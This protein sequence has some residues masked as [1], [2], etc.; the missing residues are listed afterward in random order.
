VRKKICITTG[1]R[2]DFGLFRPLLIKIRSAQDF[3][4]QLLV[5]GAHLSKKFGSTYKEIEREGHE[6]TK[7]VDIQITSDT[8]KGI[9]RSIGL[10]IIGFAKAL[11]ELKPDV[12]VL[13]GDRFE[14]LACAIAAHVL[15][16]PI[17]HIHGG[18]RTEG[19]IDDAFRHAITKMSFLHFTSAEEYRQRV[20]Q[21]GESP[22]RVFNVGALGVDNIK[23]YKLLNKDVLGKKIGF[24]FAKRNILVTFHPVTLER[25]SAK[26]QFKELL[27]AID[28]FRDIGVIFTKPNVDTDNSVIRDLIDVYVKKNSPRAVCFENMG[29]L[30]YLSALQAV[31]AVVGNSSSG[32]IEAP[33]FGIPT[34][35]IGDRQQ[36]RLM[37]KS[38]INCEPQTKQIRNA[39]KKAFSPRFA[40]FCK[41]VSNPYGAGK[42]AEKIYRVVRGTINNLSNLKKT[43]YTIGER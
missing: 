34:I 13:L 38:V 26:S 27:G 21:L 1:S 30:K 42:A 25:H 31:A 11:D 35:N 33:S 37:A 19:V 9:C 7:K 8:E 16:I 29:T 28:G 43:F 15:K 14:T 18:E 12:L 2:A 3:K 39:I 41:T 22:D 5:T 4:L 36:G 23:T 20:I 32:I 40:Q 10:G 6:I 17:A 24:N